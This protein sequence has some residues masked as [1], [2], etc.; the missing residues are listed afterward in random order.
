MKILD[1]HIH[2]FTANVID[3][4]A[5]KT[6]LVQ[7]LKLQTEGAGERIDVK[8]LQKDMLAGGVEGALML[9]TAS[10]HRVKK[11]NRDCV[12]TVSAH[13]WLMT[14]GTLHPGYPH[15]EEE[16]HYLKANGVRVIKLCSFSQGFTLDALLTLR[17]FDA[18]EAFN[19]NSET[20][21]SVV[22]DTLQGADHYFG[23]LP[24]YNTTPKLL[25][26]LADCY[27]GIN[28]IGAHMGGLDGSID[29]ICRY[30][31]ARPNLYL[32]TSNA[33]HTLTAEE[34]IRLLN[35]HGPQHILFG[36][37]W[38]WFTH[39]SEVKHIDNLL[40]RAGFSEKEKSEVF[41][42]N[43]LALVRVPNRGV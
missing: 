7:H 39:Q 29:D 1:C 27:P 30:L 14:A 20:P 15:N 8:T 26:E 40:D 9:P 33:A 28:F 25:G 42:G 19:K 35:L 22:L 10:V 11:T 4:V 13:D 38:P 43:L 5:Q 31:T 18:I 34:F 17:M 3:N 12:E 21:F 24:I 37:D 23:T 41:S 32:D 36:T 16:L 2:M 6:R